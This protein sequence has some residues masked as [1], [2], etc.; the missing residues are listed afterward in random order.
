MMKHAWDG[1]ATYAWGKNELR[2]VTHKGH[3]DSIFGSHH[4]GATIV[5]CMD[6]LYIMGLMD[7]FNKGKAWIEQNL[8]LTGIVS[9]FNL[10][11]IVF[12]I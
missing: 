5:D 3:S 11:S 1:Y 12:F 2:P 4:F 10:H 6:T 7:E 9:T 8:N